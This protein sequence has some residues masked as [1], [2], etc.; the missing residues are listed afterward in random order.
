MNNM[1]DIVTFTACFS[2]FNK[3]K[4]AQYLLIQRWATRGL[5]A[6]PDMQIARHLGTIFVLNRKRIGST[7]KESL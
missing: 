2:L 1:L 7:V 3:Q 6:D 5:H 4:F